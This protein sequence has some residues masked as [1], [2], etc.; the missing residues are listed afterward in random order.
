MKYLSFLVALTFLA[1]CTADEKP[2]QEK[3]SG[4][5][6]QPKI[7]TIESIDT[8][9]IA[10]VEP[11]PEVELTCDCRL[12]QYE[13]HHGAQVTFQ[14][15]LGERNDERFQKWSADSLIGTIKSIRF[16]GFDT[17]PERYKVFKN[18][19][20]LSI[21][22]RNGIYGMDMF[23]KLKVVDFFGAVVD[24]NTEEKWPEKVEAILAAKS[25]LNNVPFERLTNLRVLYM[26][27]SR[28]M[29]TPNDVH[30]LKCLHEMVLGAYSGRDA[31]LTKMDFS[32]NPCLQKLHLQTWG[33]SMTGVPTGLEK[34]N[35][36][37]LMISHPQ[38]S[39]EEKEQVKT[40]KE[41]LKAKR[42]VKK[43]EN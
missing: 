26:G 9:S 34:T 38:L 20:K 41:D 30:H 42:E 39:D 33:K 24:L 2:A 1:S 7:D 4:V 13:R 43:D 17:I 25:I 23:P 16:N 37:N 27:H 29:P 6:E 32:S 8:T 10:E 36:V 28:M 5:P 19:E 15:S 12:R 31:D 18:V 35:I 22:T 11:E 21:D 40:I 14:R 3:D